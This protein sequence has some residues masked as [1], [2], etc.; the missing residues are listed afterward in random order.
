MSGAISVIVF[1]ITGILSMFVY[2]TMVTDD[3]KKAAKKAK[4]AAA[5]G[6]K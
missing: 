3:S 2:K 5:K 6:V 1:I 4:K